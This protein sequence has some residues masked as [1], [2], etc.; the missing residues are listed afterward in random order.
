MPR[1]I[2]ARSPC[3]A[4]AGAICGWFALAVEEEEAAEEEKG[5]EEEA[6]EEEKGEEEEAAKEEKEEEEHTGT[7]GKAEAEE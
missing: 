1:S 5:E 4:L 6:A 2:P 7:K 3:S